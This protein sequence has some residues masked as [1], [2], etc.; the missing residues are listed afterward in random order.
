MNNILHQKYPAP[1]NVQMGV[2]RCQMGVSWGEI[3]GR[4]GSEG[5]SWG[6]AEHHFPVFFR[7]RRLSDG[8]Q[9]GSD[10]IRLGSDW[11]QLRVS[12]R[13]LGGDGGQTGGAERQI[14]V[15]CRKMGVSCVSAAVRLY[16]IQFSWGEMGGKMSEIGVRGE[17]D[18]VIHAPTAPPVD[19][20]EVN[21]NQLVFATGCGAMSRQ[22]AWCTRGARVVHA[23]YT[24]GARVVSPSP[25]RPCLGTAC[26]TTRSL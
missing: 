19:N 1:P 23:W 10:C 5:G 22:H 20:S 18:C 2:S 14:G 7:L 4:L 24:R 6:S 12:R 13:E 26:T 3:G 17:G 15:S 25:L 21:A 16:Q 11:G 8:G 9:L